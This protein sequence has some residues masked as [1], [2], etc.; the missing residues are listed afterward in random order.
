MEDEMKRKQHD[1]ERTKLEIE[2]KRQ[3]LDQKIADLNASADLDTLSETEPEASQLE[4]LL[5][6]ALSE[7]ESTK[8]A[9]AD[10]Q[11]RLEQGP[12]KGPMSFAEVFAVDESQ[13][14]ED[15][16]RMIGDVRFDVKNATAVMYARQPATARGTRIAG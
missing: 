10:S 4:G 16:W 1:I 9:L 5:A 11:S 2:T 8:A 3:E 7:L 12:G 13:V 14:K 15:I 6:K